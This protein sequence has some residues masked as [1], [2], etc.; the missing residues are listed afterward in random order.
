VPEGDTIHRAARRVGAVLTGRVPDEIFTPHPRHAM[1]RWPERLAGRAVRSVDAHGKHLFL[2]FEGDLVLHSH[3][4]MTGIWAVY[5]HGRRWGRS[6]RRAWLILRA[7]RHDVVQF[8]GP[9]LEL[10]TEARVRTDP[11]IARLGPDVLAPDF[12]PASAVPRLRAADPD[13]PL[14]E[15][16]LDQ[17]AVAGIGN[18]WKSESCWEAQLSPWRPLSGIGDAALVAVLSAARTR[19]QRS[20]EH[21]MHARDNR[22]YRREGRPCPRCRTPIEIRGQGDENRMTY[23]CPGCQ[24]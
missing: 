5:G 14:G 2:H 6:P 9:V 20:V 23:W 24:A 4:R 22:V 19:M 13:R 21:G 3:L 16:L 12:D 11:R 7:P 15:A 10:L 1:D 8:D 17:H 18:V